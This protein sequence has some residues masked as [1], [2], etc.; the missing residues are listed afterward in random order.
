MIMRTPTLLHTRTH[1]RTHR[2][3]RHVH[4]HTGLQRCLLTTRRNGGTNAR[5]WTLSSKPWCVCLV[6]V[7]CGLVVSSLR[8]CD[9]RRVNLFEVVALENWIAS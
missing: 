2:K 9:L 3:Q 6:G 1:V 7:Q 8:S 4:K 5:L